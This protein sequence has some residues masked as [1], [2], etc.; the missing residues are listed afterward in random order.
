MGVVIV[1][2]MG[3]ANVCPVTSKL[4]SPMQTGCVNFVFAYH[5]D[6]PKSTLTEKEFEKASNNFYLL[7]WLKRISLDEIWYMCKS[8]LKVNLPNRS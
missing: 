3:E 2:T 4:I 5:P 1:V 7:A 8:G 6:R